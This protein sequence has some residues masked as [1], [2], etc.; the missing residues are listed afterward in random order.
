MR[1]FNQTLKNKVRN[2]SKKLLNKVIQNSKKKVF[3]LNTKIKSLLNSKVN[4]LR[5]YYRVSKKAKQLT[6][7]KLS[8]KKISLLKYLG[9]RYM[10]ARNKKPMK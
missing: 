9:I 2:K 7:V 10:T 8:S 3:K 5:G 1:K 4:K 6:Q